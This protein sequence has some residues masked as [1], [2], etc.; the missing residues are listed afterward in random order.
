MTEL[1]KII[2]TKDKDG[3]DHYYVS[4][5]DTPHD[6]PCEITLHGYIAISDFMRIIEADGKNDKLWKP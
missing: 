6:P 4:R 2:S 3:K 1:F 5:N